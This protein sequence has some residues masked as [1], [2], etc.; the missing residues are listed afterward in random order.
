MKKSERIWDYLRGNRMGKEANRLER[1]ALSDPF[2]YEA[3][4]GLEKVEGDHEKSLAGLFMRMQKTGGEKKTFRL[5]Y[6]LSLVAACLLIAGWALWLLYVPEAPVRMARIGSLAD[7]IG[8]K[9]ET[10]IVE[11]EFAE[12]EQT[13]KIAEKSFARKRIANDQEEK[14]GGARIVAEQESEEAGKKND[15]PVPYATAPIPMSDKCNKSEKWIEG[16]VTDAKGQPLP[17]AS[18]SLRDNKPRGSSSDRHGYF[19]LSVPDS[20]RQLQVSFVGMKSVVLNIPD[21]GKVH[22]TM[23]EFPDGLSEVMITGYRNFANRIEKRKKPKAVDIGRQ[24]E[25]NQYVAD[26][27]RYPEDAR[28]RGIE[29]KVVLSVHLNRRRHSM[30]IK[31]VDKLFPSCDREAIRLVEDFNG[32]WG[33]E[34]RDFKVTVSFQ[35]PPSIQ[36]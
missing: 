36:H 28:L 15:E 31:V 26:S 27:L 20:T 21:S 10:G 33:T 5:F 29:G 9:T 30:R 11:P 3:L 34:S 2:L 1:E 14:A 16:I 6:S 7:S 13:V 4:E 23:T 35:L 18:I 25:F 12:A 24:T 17:G 32:D 8:Q 22:V 19:M